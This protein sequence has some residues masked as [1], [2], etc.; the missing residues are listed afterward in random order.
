[1]VIFDH[2]CLFDRGD[3]AMIDAFLDRDQDTSEIQAVAAHDDAN[4]SVP[5][6]MPRALCSELHFCTWGFCGVIQVFG[7]GGSPS[8]VA[9]R[10]FRVLL[11]MVRAD[12]LFPFNAKAL[13]WMNLLRSAIWLPARRLMLC[14]PIPKT[15]III[16]IAL[17]Y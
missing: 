10:D 8:P 11:L 12:A 6:V 2:L 13:R 17:A 7:F 15:L 5:L 14:S 4:K 1:M 16:L 3:R 9:A